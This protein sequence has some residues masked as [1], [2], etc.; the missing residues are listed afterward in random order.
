MSTST[1]SSEGREPA[2]VARGLVRR[3]GERTAVDQVSFEIEPGE[4]FGLLGPNGSGKSTLIRMLCGVLSP[5][6]GG[7]TVLGFDMVREPESVKRRIGYMS[8]R[9]SLYSSLSVEENLVSYARAYGLDPTRAA[10]RIA[11]VSELAGITDRRSQLAGTLSGGWK[12]RLALACALIHEPRVLFLDEP[13]AGIDPVARRELWDLLFDLAGRGITL[14]VTTHYMDEAERCSRVGYI[15]EGRLIVSGRPDELKALNHVTPPGTRRLEFRPERPAAVLGRLRASRG[16]IDATLFGESVHLLVDESF[17]P[18]ELGAG[19]EALASLRP[20]AP[21]LEDVFVTFARAAPPAGAPSPAL[22]ARPPASPATVSEAAERPF[23]GLF[24]VLA[25]ELA[26]VRR[27][28]ATLLFMFVI[29]IV[30]MIIFGFAIQ[31]EVEDIPTIV[32]D[33]DRK[34]KS[35]ELADAFESTRTFEV[36]ERVLDEDTFDRAMASGRAKVGLRIPPG[37]GERLLRGEGAEA[38]VLID[39]SESS[40]AN[41]ALSST[42]LLGNALSR[43]IGMRIAESNQRAPARDEFGHATLP[44]DLRPRLLYNPDLESSRFFV[45]GL[46]GIILQLVTLFLTAF[47]IARERE[48]GTLEQLFVTPIGRAGLLLGKLLPYSMVGVFEML[49]VFVLMVYA[50]GLP[51]AG[52]LWLLLGLSMLFLLTSLSLGLLISTLARTQLTAMQLSFLVMLPSVLLSGFMFPR[53]EMPALI[54]AVSYA[55]PVSYFVEILR[56]VI[57][58]GAGLVD[59]APHAIGLL[60]CG[61]IL[62]VVSVSRFQKKLA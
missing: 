10:P 43:D 52:S 53:A 30:Q 13:T 2:I 8:Q 36:V 25:K 55:L 35:R 26:H 1:T 6:E 61:M 51:I 5:S 24:A 41:A 38:Q 44:Y 21:N 17:D 12:Q 57:L 56:G 50:F 29:P 27:E 22:P 15:S 33:L 37:F 40:V 54:R 14:F 62:L 23:F 11:V 49:L 34:E 16:V 39:G 18:K 58:R 19:A 28:P 9:F 47:S 59:L 20:I 4:I 48:H 46:V 60:A 31:T 7:A 32:L 3:F 42:K 45:P